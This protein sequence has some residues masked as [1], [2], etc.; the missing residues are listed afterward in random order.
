MLHGRPGSGMQPIMQLKAIQ[1]LEET[2]TLVYFDQRGTGKSYYDLRQGIS[3]E[4]VVDDVKVVVDFA[5]ET[6]PNKKICLWG[7]SYGGLLGL[8][9]LD[10]FPTAVEK[11]VISSPA[12]YPSSEEMSTEQ[13]K[14][15]QGIEN[16]I[17]P[18][19][20]S[21][22]LKAITPSKESAYRFL[23]AKETQDFLNLYEMPV[24][25]YEALFHFNAMKDWFFMDC[26]YRKTLVAIQIPTL[27]L[28]GMDDPFCF[29]ETLIDAYQ[30]SNNALIT[31]I[32]Y[33]NCGHAVFE[34]C[35]DEFVSACEEFYQL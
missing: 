2:F 30:A 31:L 33:E 28:Q 5:K 26:D 12:I 15:F 4:Q 20:L 17:F 21:K 13:F 3:K 25:Y 14:L 10:R 18:T 24:P 32:T 34:D 35:E 9:F 6:F 27:L 23:S 19:E 8:M 7:G 16:S 22:K 11:A 29:A 1:H